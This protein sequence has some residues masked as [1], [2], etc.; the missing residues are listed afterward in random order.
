L[1]YE[2]FEKEFEY[3]Q[4]QEESKAI[5]KQEATLFLKVLYAKICYGEFL[6]QNHKQCH[7]DEVFMMYNHLY[8]NKY[9]PM[10]EYC[11]ELLLDSL[12]TPL[13]PDMKGEH[14]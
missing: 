6:D 14:A 11:A 10:S 9:I 1:G 2:S 5:I 12:P 13:I 3:C 4:K 7:R 8:F